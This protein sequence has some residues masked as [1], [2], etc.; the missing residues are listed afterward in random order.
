LAGSVLATEVGA[1]DTRSTKPSL[2]DLEFQLDRYEPEAR[3]AFKDEALAESATYNSALAG[4]V[5][6]PDDMPQ[7]KK[8]WEEWHRQVRAVV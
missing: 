5:Q 7:L 2:S 3:K 1:G 6:D 4:I 8:A